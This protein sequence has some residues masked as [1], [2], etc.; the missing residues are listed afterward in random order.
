M[1][2]K[3]WLIISLS[4]NTLLLIA[5][6]LFAY[7]WID[8]II[9]TEHQNDKLYSALLYEEQIKSLLRDGF[10]GI[11]K[12]GLIEVFKKRGYIDAIVERGDRVYLDDI[13]FVFKGGKLIDVE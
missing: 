5:S 4:F 7:L 8:R 10:Y 3:T 12:N 1:C 2:K 13:C 9:S 6:I 11:S